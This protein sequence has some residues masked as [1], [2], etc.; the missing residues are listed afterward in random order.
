MGVLAM[1]DA[2]PR[3]P[4]EELL[5][6][7]F[8]EVLDVP[9]VGVDDSFFDLGGDSIVS[10]RLV[11]RAREAGLEFD[12]RDVFTHPSVAALA[13]VARDVAAPEPETAEPETPEPET[14]ASEDAG[15]EGAVSEPAESEHTGPEPAGPESA[16]PQAGKRPLVE[17]TQDELDDI[18]R[19]IS[20][21]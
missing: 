18:E 1:A 6:Q 7:L 4:R 20:Q 5:C 9:E 10:M 19:Q 16:G 8:A 15:S 13:A 21:M 17:L 2:R 3:N 11:G 12:R 14:A